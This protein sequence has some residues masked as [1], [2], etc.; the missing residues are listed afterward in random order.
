VLQIFTLLNTIFTLTFS[1]A[2]IYLISFVIPPYSAYGSLLVINAYNMFLPFIIISMILLFLS[3]QQIEHQKSTLQNKINHSLINQQ[4]TQLKKLYSFRQDFFNSL[5]KESLNIVS[6]TQNNLEKL[7][8]KVKDLKSVNDYKKYIQ[9]LKKYNEIMNN[10]AL[11]INDMAKEFHIFNK[12]SLEKTNIISYIGDTLDQNKLNYKDVDVS[13]ASDEPE[14]TLLVDQDIIGNI[15]RN[16]VSIG[17]EYY[18]SPSLEVSIKLGKVIFGKN[19]YKSYSVKLLF[20]Q[21]SDSVSQIVKEEDK[22]VLWQE[23]LRL[24][25]GHYIGL[26]GNHQKNTLVYTIEIPIEINTLIPKSRIISKS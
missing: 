12:L 21:Y 20:E 16:L 22:S 14:K 17:F 15:V 2:I 26:T 4:A 8:D 5:E 23:T 9:E 3:R 1:S 18:L 25:E 19:S 11:Y 6:E 10:S 13:F 24:A 7:I